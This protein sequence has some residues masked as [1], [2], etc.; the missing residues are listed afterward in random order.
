MNLTGSVCNGNG[1]FAFEAGY[2]EARLCME[3]LVLCRAVAVCW[4]EGRLGHQIINGDFEG[5]CQLRQCFN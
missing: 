1:L 2:F 3:R 4:G 5:A